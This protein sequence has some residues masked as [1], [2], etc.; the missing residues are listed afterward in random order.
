[1]KKGSK[2]FLSGMAAAMMVMSLLAGCGSSNAAQDT[3]SKSGS[4]ETA[5]SSDKGT[6]D[7]PVV[8]MCV[9][10]IYD[11]TDLQ[12]VEDAIN[13]ITAEKYGVKIKLTFVEFGNWTNQSNMLLTGDEADLIMIY[14][15]PLLTYVKN[16]QLA[17]MDDYYN[18]ASEE[19]KTA[20]AEVFTDKDLKCTSVN[21]HIYALPN[22][23]NHGDVIVLDIDRAIADEMGVKGG[24]QMSLDQ[25]DELL[26]KIHEAYPD[27]YAI[28]PQGNTT[29]SNGGWTWD[30]LG[31]IK[32]IGVME[33]GGDTTIKNLLE[34]E[35]FIDL[36]K[37]THSW[38]TNGYMMPDCLSNTETGDSMILNKKAVTCFNNGAY[39]DETDYIKE[40]LVRVPLTPAK[41]DTTT[42]SG[43]CWGISANSKNKDASWKMLEVLYSDADVVTLLTD[44]IKDR[45]YVVDA[46]GNAVYP[47]G[48]DYTNN[49]YG[50]MQQW[51]LYP[52]SS[53]TPEQPTNGLT[54]SLKK[55]NESVQQTP[56]YGFCFDT[57][58]VT[59][60]YSACCNVMDKYY[61]ALMLGAVDPDEYLAKA[62][63]E[64]KAAGMDKVIEAKQK[65]FDAWHAENK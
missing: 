37:H 41:A 8:N 25:V 30:G 39:F 48:K 24:E 56:A 51:W 9:P 60:E 61:S 32:M 13:E 26:G 52:N 29:M 40:D 4:S 54:E 27:R 33:A 49:G 44:G 62:T 50:A 31:D 43:M 45:N 16:G 35:D 34:I 53:L 2:R 58:E 20:A 36:T 7:V 6:T 19:F 11:T 14:G 10:N 28:V 18:N 64:L 57:T 5:A 55:F 22:Y 21:G 47:D 15:T 23:R 3:S 65:Q 59:D 1:M 17:N 63:E 42:I 46:D 38:Y 12:M